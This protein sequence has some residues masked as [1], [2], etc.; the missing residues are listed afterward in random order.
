MTPWHR[1]WFPQ[2]EDDAPAPMRDAALWT[3]QAL[4]DAQ[5]GLWQQAAQATE[6]WWRFWQTA[7]PSLPGQ[8]PV[9]MV[10]APIDEEA[11]PE[12]PTQPS[13]ASTRRKPAPR[14]ATTVTAAPKRARAG[15]RGK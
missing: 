2:H 3:P 8:P 15:S 13:L 5:R 7:W 14:R 10:V 4:A 12:P 11:A 1:F 9:G 6:D